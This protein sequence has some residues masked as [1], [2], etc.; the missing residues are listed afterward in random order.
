MFQ[1]VWSHMRQKHIYT[2]IDSS[3]VYLASATNHHFLWLTS[4]IHHCLSWGEI[5]VSLCFKSTFITLYLYEH[6]N[7]F[8]VVIIILWPYNSSVF[9][10]FLVTSSIWLIQFKVCIQLADWHGFVFTTIV[11]QYNYMHL[12]FKMGCHWQHMSAPAAQLLIIK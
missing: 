6:I 9:Y 8:N 1:C 10:L 7:V 11:L 4:I 2:H 3:T 12:D 5:G